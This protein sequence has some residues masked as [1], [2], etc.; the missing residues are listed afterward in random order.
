MNPRRVLSLHTFGSSGLFASVLGCFSK[1]VAMA[2]LISS[3]I[4]FED[5]ASGMC[6]GD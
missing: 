4:K 2:F 5:I 1:V 3:L 6:L